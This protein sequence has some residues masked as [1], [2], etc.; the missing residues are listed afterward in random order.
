MTDCV[1]HWDIHNLAVHDDHDA[2]VVDNVY[3]SDHREALVC[4]DLLKLICVDSL[5]FTNTLYI[6]KLSFM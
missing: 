1:L 2:L 4:P 3:L 5:I 6:L